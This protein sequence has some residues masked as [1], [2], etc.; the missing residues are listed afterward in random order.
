[1]KVDGPAWP[2]AVL[3]RGLAANPDAV[4]LA[5][6][7]ARFTW[8]ELDEA[9]SRLAGAYLRLG[10]KPGDRVASL[11]PNRAA[12]IVHY[13]ACFKDTL[14]ATPLNYRYTPRE[15]DHA[16][17][18]SESS[19]LIA[20]AEREV[21]VAGSEYVRKLP[22]GV[23]RFGES[24]RTLPN[25]EDL[26]ANGPS[27]TAL[28]PPDP[29]ATASIFFTSGSTGLPKGVTHSHETLGWMFAATREGL[30]LTPKDVMVTGSS[31]SHIAAQSLAFASLA[32]GARVAVPRSLDGDE[33]LPLLRRETPTVL[34][35]LPAPL[36]RLIRDHNAKH[37]DFASLRLCV[38]GG[39]KV[40]LELEQ[41]FKT[42]TGLAID[43]VYGMTETGTTTINPPSGENRLGSIGQPV[44][45]YQIS[46]RDDA[47]R[48]LP[49]GSEGRLW[50]KSPTMMVGYWRNPDATRDVIRDG[51]LDTG[52]IMKQDAEG[53]LWFRGRKK[54]IIVHDGSNVC[55]QEI[56]EALLEHP[57]LE[58]AGV[59]GVHDLV[60]GENVRAYV[61]FKPGAPRPSGAELIAFTRARVGYKA[62]EDIVVLDTLPL[63]PVGKTDRT[64]LKRLAEA[65][66]H[67]AI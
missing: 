11:M 45:P 65:D 43:E 58:S 26:I 53:Y 37:E 36:F 52:D 40:A 57:A 48:E 9:S 47:G 51:W 10:L 46:I 14:A 25:L 33:V 4:A 3:A 2:H 35:M 44:P 34:L 42:L 28:P 22:L 21:D 32:A 23:V 1:M 17:S 12:L 61:A 30:E 13:L 16:L 41:E 20:H 39:D 67:R 15:I 38:S 55:P 7:D 63:T 31:L 18:V 64:A 6:A 8:R 66:V 56:E 50:V 27:N 5:D 60:H 62:P 19:I 24:N 29:A 59:V 54:Q 49:R